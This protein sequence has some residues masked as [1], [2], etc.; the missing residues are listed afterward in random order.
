MRLIQVFEPPMCCSTGVCGPEVDPILVQF[1]ADLDALKSSEVN[2]ERFN[3]SQSPQQFVSAS[4]IL[5]LLRELGAGAL[6]AILLDGEL[7]HHGSYPDRAMLDAIVAGQQKAHAASAIERTR[8][9]LANRRSVIV[10]AAN[11]NR[12][13]FLAPF[14]KLAS[15]PAFAESVEIVE[16]TGR[17]DERALMAEV[18][19]QEGGEPAAVLIVPPGYITAQWVGSASENDILVRLLQGLSS[20]APG[21]GC[22]S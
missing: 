8:A 18:G 4:P 6:P 10:C 17:D 14:R 5:A 1:A 22:C 20:C 21:G 2:V 16:L 12:D 13:T 7:V 3:L 9:A 11:G 19:L 15:T